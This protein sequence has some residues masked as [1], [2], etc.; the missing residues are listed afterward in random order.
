MYAGKNNINI[1][2]GKSG[3][4]CFTEKHKKEIEL[5]FLLVQGRYT[6]YIYIYNVKVN[7][8]AFYSLEII[9][10]ILWPC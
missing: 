4:N 3:S 7:H 9:F 5:Y 2:L 6:L 10:N 1:L 8:L